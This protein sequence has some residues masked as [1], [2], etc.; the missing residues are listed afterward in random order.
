V[1]AI[2]KSCSE[3]F[4]VTNMSPEL[5]TLDSLLGGELSLAVIRAL[6]PDAEAFNRGVLA[7]LSSGEV[8]VLGVDGG[9]VPSWL[10]RQLFAAEGVANEL[11][12]LR[13]KITDKGIQRMS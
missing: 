4:R 2:T 12:L 6:Y 9:A 5:E 13:I 10:W 11:E 3:E 8:C 1:T 7:L